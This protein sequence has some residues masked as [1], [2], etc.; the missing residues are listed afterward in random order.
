MFGQIHR[1]TLGDL[2]GCLALAQDREWRPE[3][4]KW[5]LLFEVGTGYG[6]R[7]EAGDLVGTTILTR[8]GSGLAAISM[9]LVAARCGG[10]GLGRRLMTHALAEAGDGTVFL[11][12]TEYGRPLY[13]KL[14]FVSVGTTYTYVGGFG[15]PGGRA[16]S[17]SA[18]LGDLK[19][20]RELDAHVNGADRT[21][22]VERLPGFA[23]Q[24][25]VVERH[26]LITGYAG[27]WRNA[28][29]VIIGPVIAG[30]IDDAKALIAD[31][32]GAVT[33]SVRL[34]LDNR[35][36]QLREWAVQHGFALRTS[37]AVMVLDGRPLPGD[38]ARWFIPLMQAL[39]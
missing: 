35:Y 26:G 29:N 30:N 25:R 20:I 28:D 23:E 1:L 22:L 4:R 39:G 33:G 14:G 15:S 19:V 2:P 18:V 17:R 3:E 11:N 24:L 6:L 38:R 36:P 9:V 13:E 16:S 8:Y 27:A 10:R 32:A 37:S 7:D 31:L 5:R 34:D 12:A 21:H